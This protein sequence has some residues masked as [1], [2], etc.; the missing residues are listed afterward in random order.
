MRKKPEKRKK[1]RKEILEK[2]ELGRKQR[3]DVKVEEKYY[4]LK[5]DEYL[6]NLDDKGAEFVEDIEK[7]ISEIKKLD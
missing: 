7:N 4:M 6:S 2:E 1:T 3:L 5:V